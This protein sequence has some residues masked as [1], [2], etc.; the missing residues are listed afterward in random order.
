MRIYLLNLLLDLYGTK[1][2]NL[3]IF[4][5]ITIIYCFLKG[6]LYNRAVENFIVQIKKTVLIYR[7]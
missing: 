6:K 1:K 7:S 2:W 5:F 3:K 4:R